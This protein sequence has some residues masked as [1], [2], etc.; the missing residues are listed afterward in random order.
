[1][2]KRVYKAVS[3]RAG[4]LCELC[5]QYKPLQ[6]HHIVGGRGKRKQHETVDSCIMLCLDCHDDVEGNIKLDRA[7]KKMVQAI[8]AGKGHG[9]TEIRR[10]MGGK[11]Y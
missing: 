11:L 3:D 2:D 6:L 8:Y 7:L 4:G 10:M 1:M 9:E 5:Y